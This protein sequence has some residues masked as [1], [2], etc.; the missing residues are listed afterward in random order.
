[1]AIGDEAALPQSQPTAHSCKSEEHIHVSKRK[2][3]FWA[4]TGNQR[5][6]HQRRGRVL[7]E[8][9]R[10]ELVDVQ[11]RA[12]VLV[13]RV[14]RAPHRVVV[15]GH[16]HLG[17]VQVAL[18][19]TGIRN[20]THHQHHH[21]APREESYSSK[22]SRSPHETCG[23]DPSCSKIASSRNHAPLV[24]SCCRTTTTNSQSLSWPESYHRLISTAHG[25]QQDMFLTWRK[26]KL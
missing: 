2:N 15:L 5:P 16:V 7:V 12:V 11:H 17:V 25:D 24:G 4:P 8:V 1:M 26:Y 18:P 19:V 21:P 6:L 23:V 3:P 20:T 14:L 10:P 13:A 22:V 9:V